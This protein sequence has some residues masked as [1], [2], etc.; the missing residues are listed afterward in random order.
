MENPK[1]SLEFDFGSNNQYIRDSHNID[2]LI[3]LKDRLYK[4]YKENANIENWI[5]ILIGNKSD[6]FGKKYILNEEKISLMK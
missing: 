4:F 3:D 1:K 6:I 5:Y 2:S